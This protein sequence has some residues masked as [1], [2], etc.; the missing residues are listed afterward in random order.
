MPNYNVAISLLKVAAVSLALTTTSYSADY[1]IDILGKVVRVDDYRP[2][3]GTQS[4]PSAVGTSVHFQIDINTDTVLYEE[5]IEGFAPFNN[6]TSTV[7]SAFHGAVLEGPELL[8]TFAVSGRPYTSRLWYQD[9][10]NNMNMLLGMNSVAPGTINPAAT[11][12]QFQP[13]EFIAPFT[14]LGPL[15]GINT[16]VDL[17]GYDPAFSAF[18]YYSYVW[19]NNIPVGW[20]V[21][22]APT[23][24]AVTAIPEPSAL[25]LIVLGLGF[26]VVHARYRKIDA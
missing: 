16:H 23:S 14:L 1:R 21:T 3:G 25:L 2:D 26:A 5:G 18:T 8:S 9:R 12:F 19:Q 20:N 7:P 22:Y 11:G 24:Y 15:Q 4:R 10:G 13:Q 17:T 6:Y